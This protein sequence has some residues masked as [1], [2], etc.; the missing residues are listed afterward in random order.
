MEIFKKIEK[1]YDTAIIY[2]ISLF[3]IIFLFITFLIL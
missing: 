3:T 2:G 1:K